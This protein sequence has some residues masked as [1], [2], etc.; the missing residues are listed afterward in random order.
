MMYKGYSQFYFVTQSVSSTVS[1]SIGQ[2]VSWSVS[3]NV[4]DFNSIK[5]NIKRRGRRGSRLPFEC[6]TGNCI[7]G[8][9][10]RY[11]SLL[12]LFLQFFS[13]PSS[14]KECYNLKTYLAKV[15]GSVHAPSV[16]LGAPR[17]HFVFC[18]WW[19]VAGGEEFPA[20]PIG[21]E[22]KPQLSSLSLDISLKMKTEL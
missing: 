1:R 7:S 12:P 16:I 14:Q 11:Y 10:F 4:S 3:K 6:S 21:Q 18:R 20:A 15:D 9:Y 8:H 13:P 17:D 5:Q 22:F 2:S 19:G